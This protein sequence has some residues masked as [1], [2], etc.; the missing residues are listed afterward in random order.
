MIIVSIV[1]LVTVIFLVS[2]IEAL[3]TRTTKVKVW[4]REIRGLKVNDPVLY[5]GVNVGR[6]VGLTVEEAQDGKAPRVVLTLELES[7]YRLREDAV[8]RIGK[9]FT[10]KTSVEIRPGKGALL[11]KNAVHP[12]EPVPELQDITKQ[13]QQ[14]LGDT[15]AKV[16]RVLDGLNDMLGDGQRESVRKFIANLEAFADKLNQV[17][18]NLATLTEAKGEVQGSLASIRGAADSTAKFLNTHSDGVGSLL[19]ELKET[20][21]QAKDALAQARKSA[22]SATQ[23]LQTAAETLGKLNAM[24]D[25]NAADVKTTVKNV[26]DAAGSLRVW[27][28]DVKRHPW[29]AIRKSAPPEGEKAVS[30][31]AQDLDQILR[32]LDGSLE[33]LLALTETPNAAVKQQLGEVSQMVSQLKEAAAAVQSATGEMK[34]K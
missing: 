29:K 14:K 20:A 10:G 22:D 23:V 2:D 5:A 26:R 25:S 12:G 18:Q 32:R 15:Q 21:A 1:A 24:L 31:A 27:A 33:K 9:T 3:F 19:A 16:N 28:D 6:V 8:V 30:V 17:G 13:I 7:R 34:K 11:P 4:F